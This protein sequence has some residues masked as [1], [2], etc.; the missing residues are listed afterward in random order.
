MID[1][2][3]VKRLAEECGV[4][5]RF[6]FNFADE[7]Q[8]YADFE[9]L[10]KFAN[11]IAAHQRE[12]DAGIANQYADKVKATEDAHYRLS[13]DQFKL[14]NFGFDCAQLKMSRSIAEAIR[15]QGEPIL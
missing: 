11:A 9:S 6:E 2:S 5:E 13:K 10:T 14:E 12:I 3:A 1:K 4:T 7:A 15:T 8:T